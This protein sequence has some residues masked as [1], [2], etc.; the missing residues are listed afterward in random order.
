LSAWNSLAEGVGALAEED[1]AVNSEWVLG[2][3]KSAV[4]W[5]NQLA[6]R[7]WTP[8]DITDT[9][10]NGDQFPAPNKVNPGNTATRYQNPDTGRYV[11]RD[12]VTNEILQVSRPD[13]TANILPP[14]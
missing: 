7:N 12:D 2:N 3:F 9:I 6:S 1:A 10:L 5:A 8:E 13:F 14:E 11:V 4:R